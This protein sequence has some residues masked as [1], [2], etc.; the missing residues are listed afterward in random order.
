MLE[1]NYNLTLEQR[2]LLFDLEGKAQDIENKFQT[3][4]DWILF[5]S[6]AEF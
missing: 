5:S 1:H 3:A 4:A 6:E 2:T